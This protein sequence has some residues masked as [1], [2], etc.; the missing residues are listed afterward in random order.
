MV[1]AAAANGWLDRE[2]AILETL[3]VDQAGRRRHRADLLG[4]RGG[5]PP[6]VTDR[7]G[8]G[9]RSRRAG[10]KLRRP[11]VGFAGAFFAAASGWTRRSPAPGCCRTHRAGRSRLSRRRRELADDLRRAL[12]EIAA[13][14]R[15][16]TA[17]RRR[18]GRPRRGRRGCA[19]H[20]R[21]G[22][23]G[24]RLAERA[25]ARAQRGDRTARRR[26]R[27]RRPDPVRG[28]AH[29][30]PRRADRGDR[31]ACPRPGRAGGRAERP[32][33]A[34]RDRKPCRPALPDGRLRPARPAAGPAEL[35]RAAAVFV[36]GRP[37]VGFVQIEEV[38]GLA[39][40]VELAVI[41]RW[42]RQGIGTALVDRACEWAR[43]HATRRSP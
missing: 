38:D 28:P 41:P 22:A 2:R 24:S 26:P 19:R 33:A 12:A 27:C 16:R 11:T 18:G 4:R 6:R 15:R 23:S 39:Y 7:P 31:P 9:E 8:R 37:P 40:L 21:P 42:M 3:T 35:E 1:E 25:A 13:P 14:E 10:P 5:Y 30:R 29:R 20:R 36:A 34:R 17:R 32:A 43:A